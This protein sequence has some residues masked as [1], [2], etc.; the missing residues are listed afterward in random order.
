MQKATRVINHNIA[1]PGG[2]SDATSRHVLVPGW[3]RRV[4]ACITLLT[5]PAPPG[6]LMTQIYAIWTRHFRY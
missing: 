5:A 3:Y 1:E 2:A 4:T 6:H